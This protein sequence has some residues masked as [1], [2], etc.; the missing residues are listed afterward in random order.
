[1]WTSCTS[2]P[3]GSWSGA[4]CDLL[5]HE[6]I[7]RNLQPDGESQNSQRLSNIC[8]PSTPTPPTG[9]SF[10]HQNLSL[11]HN[12]RVVQSQH[13]SRTKTIIAIHHTVPSPVRNDNIPPRGRPP[14]IPTKRTS[15]EQR[16]QSRQYQLPRVALKGQ[17]TARGEV[18]IIVDR[19]GCGT[20]V[21][22]H[23]DRDGAGTCWDF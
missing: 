8:N 1:M 9:P 4:G 3:W 7:G 20:E 15:R 5:P 22:G 12:R 14:R 10:K 17:A 11:G 16:V 2:P 13:H 6:A 18:G 23:A 19:E 21:A